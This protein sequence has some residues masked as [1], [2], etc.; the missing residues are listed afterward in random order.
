MNSKLALWLLIGLGICV[1][2][3][4]ACL[5]VTVVGVEAAWAAAISGGFVSV[6]S[7]VVTREYEL[8]ARIREEQSPKKVPI[9]EEFMQFAQRAVLRPHNQEPL[10]DEELTKAVVRFTLEFVTWGS[11]SVLRSFIEFSKSLCTSTTPESCNKA[12]LSLERLMFDIR[13]DLGHKNRK[14]RPK[15]ILGLFTKDTDNRSS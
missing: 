12:V 3:V 8:K 5:L 11:D 6:V 2:A 7:V 10:K 13:R 14:L 1:A 15:D 9:Y 4:L